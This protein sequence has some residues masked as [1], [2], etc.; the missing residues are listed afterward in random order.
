MAWAVAEA[1][2]PKALQGQA[3]TE[4]AVAKVLDKWEPVNLARSLTGNHRKD[5]VAVMI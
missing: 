2:K 1:S 4:W 5:R 3:I